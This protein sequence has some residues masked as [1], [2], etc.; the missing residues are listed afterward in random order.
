VSTSSLKSNSHLSIINQNG[1]WRF[2]MLD[3]GLRGKA[4]F[5]HPTSDQNPERKP[6]RLASASAVHQRSIS[7]PGFFEPLMNANIR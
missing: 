6:N 1:V 4:R 7:G 2:P 3:G 5:T